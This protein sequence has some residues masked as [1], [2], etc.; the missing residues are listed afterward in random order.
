MF[1]L[2][3]Q[4]CSRDAWLAEADIPKHRPKTSEV[5]AAR[6]LAEMACRN[7]LLS[8]VVTQLLC[9]PD[10]GNKSSLLAK[11][12]NT[13][14]TPLIYLTLALT[15]IAKETSPV[16]QRFSISFHQCFNPTPKH[17]L[18]AQPFIS[19]GRGPTT[20]FHLKQ[21]F[22]GKSG[23]DFRTETLQIRDDETRHSTMS[24]FVCGTLLDFCCSFSGRIAAVYKALSEPGSQV[25][26][27]LWT[28]TAD[29]QQLCLQ[30][31]GILR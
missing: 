26:A 29:T 16:L 9:Q 8:R 11:I 31:S 20:A 12:I 2:C 10:M 14:S 23:S 17:L 30:L 4:I 3:Q 22:Y 25:T 27:L 18:L 19:N 1:R 7:G 24:A 15:K 13:L 28:H 6:P 5:T 21:V